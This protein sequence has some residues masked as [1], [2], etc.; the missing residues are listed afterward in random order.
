VKASAPAASQ[1]AARPWRTTASGWPAW[2]AWW[3]SRDSSTPGRPASSA[4]AR[5]LPATLAVEE[6]CRS[7]AR[8]AS[9]WRNQTC[10]GS[11][12][13]T[14]RRSASSSTAVSPSTSHRSAWPGTVESSSRARWVG[15]LRRPSRAST[16]SRTVAGTSTPGL[17]STSVTK[18]GLPAAVDGAEHGVPPGHRLQ[19]P[20]QGAAGAAGHV[21]ERP[22]GPRRRQVVAGPHQHP[23]VG[24]RLPGSASRSS[25]P[26]VICP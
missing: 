2:W 25:G 13:S 20:G 26:A 6:R 7:M 24:R 12:S 17:A 9:S 4:R 21:P 16:A 18:K 15:P 1:A 5:R 22:Q 8:R 19:R 14:P 23:G 10:P 3:A 11:A